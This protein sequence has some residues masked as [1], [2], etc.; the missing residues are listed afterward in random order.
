MRVAGIGPT[1]FAWEA[2]VLPLYYTRRLILRLRRG[3]A[4]HKAYSGEDDDG[5][6]ERQEKEMLYFSQFR[7][8]IKA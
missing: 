6:A 8:E 1:P 2:N 3:G 7:E 4:S 5:K